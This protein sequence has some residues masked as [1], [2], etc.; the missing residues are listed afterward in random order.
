MVQLKEF[1]ENSTIARLD[2]NALPSYHLYFRLKI[3]SYAVSFWLTPL[4]ITGFFM[5]LKYD[6]GCIFVF[7]TMDKTN[8][9]QPGT[10]NPG[11]DPLKDALQKA[12]SIDEIHKGPAAKI[13]ADSREKEDDPCKNAES[14]DDSGE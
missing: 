13:P 5:Q 11:T 10:S 9:I 2:G 7:L 3:F 12:A 8:T 6:Q 14:A 1:P 4:F